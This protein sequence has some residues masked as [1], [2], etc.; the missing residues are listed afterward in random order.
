MGR[1][2]MADIM[3]PASVRKEEVGIS[4]PHN[5]LLARAKQAL[6]SAREVAVPVTDIRPFPDQPRKYFNPDSI[7]R[8]SES[9]GAGGQTTSGMIREKPGAT[10]FELIDGERRWRAIF[11][12]PEDRRPLY[13]ARLIEAEDDVVQ[14]LISGI[15]N[16]NRDGHTP[17]EVM[18]TIDRLVKFGL[19]I[20]EISGVL[21]ISEHWTYQMHGLK[22]LT[23]EVRV[24]LD[25][26]RGKRDLLPVA[27]AIQISKIEGRLQLALAE[28]VLRKEVSLSKLRGE[29]VRVAKKEG[30]AIRVRDVSPLKRWASL[31]SKIQVANRQLMDVEA[32][33][34]DLELRRY[35]KAYP[36]DTNHSLQNLEAIQ[37][38]ATS[39]SIEFLKGK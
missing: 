27:A 23:S 15:A 30:A 8:L 26:T 16:F 36:R 12:I 6:D 9:I 17:L 20:K 29:V 34:G 19:T 18:E 31:V 4:T 28:R 13:K 39:C 1:G 11:Q 7:R 32:L 10:P 3:I 33:L 5:N 25:P 35:M 22:K 14:Y 38:L 24:L 37:K 21:G 2:Y